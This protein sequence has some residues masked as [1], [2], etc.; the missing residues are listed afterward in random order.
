MRVV[1]NSFNGRYADNPRA[2]HRGLRRTGAAY[3]HVWLADPQHAAAFPANVTTVPIG[4]PQGLAALENA[5]L[6]IAN[7]HTDLDPWQKRQGTVYLQTWHGT[8]LKAIHRSAV[9]Q[10]PEEVMDAL[11]VEIAMWDH[12]ISPSPAA[13]ELLR[14]A[15]GYRGSVL[16]TGYPR[17]DVLNAPDREQHREKVRHRL[18]LSDDAT[19]IL[20]A[21]TFRDDEVEGEV[22]LGLDVEALAGTLAANVVLLV[23]QHYFLGHR[24]RYPDR[25]TLR[26]VSA[27][28]DIAD[29]YLAADVLVTDYSSALFDF[30]VTGKPLV[31]YAY[32]F[33][34]YRDRL[35]GFTFDL[36]AESPGPIV[37]NQD[38]LTAVLRDLPGLVAEF[39]TPYARFRD[40]YCRLE[41]GHATERV[42]AQLA[43]G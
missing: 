26:D 4:S 24:Q 33:E 28:P 8:P 6:V 20:Y 22:P 32:D 42:L 5:D 16:E 10:P 17:N 13:T 36:L 15:F 14:S 35:R 38:E 7:T 43:L 19:V 40:R 3:E 27:Y 2:I 31:L 41:D 11:D 39:A 25:P 9:W 1:Y 34:H 12:L 30:A 21:P 37:Q 18:H 23:R 29:L